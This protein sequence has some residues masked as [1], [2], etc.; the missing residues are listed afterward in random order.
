MDRENPDITFAFCH[1]HARRYF[2]EVLKA[3]PKGQRDKAK[4]M[5]AHE[6]LERIAGI[7]HMDNQL[8]EFSAE[9]RYRKHQLLVG[10][11]VEAL[12]SWLKKV[13]DEKMVPEGRKMMKG[14]NY[15]LNHEKQ[16]REF[17][18]HGN[19]PLDNNAIESALRNFCMH[20]Y[21]GD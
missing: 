17:L 4:G 2:A 1:A 21:T 15:Y 10:P 8:A 5:V 9:E 3:I 7:Y 14:V 20:K 12:F 16:F 11:L 6:A 18:N 19:I 13:R